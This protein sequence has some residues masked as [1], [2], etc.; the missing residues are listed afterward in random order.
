MDATQWTIYK[1]NKGIDKAFDSYKEVRKDH[2]S[3]REQ[4]IDGLAAAIQET[5]NKQK[6]AIV[7]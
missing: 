5:G 7:K 2:E 1:L 4:F 3:L 6:A